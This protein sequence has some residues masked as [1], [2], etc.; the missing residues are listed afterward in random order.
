MPSAGRSPSNFTSCLAVATEATM[1]GC[2]WSLGIGASDHR[3]PQNIWC[4]SLV[5]GGPWDVP[6]RAVFSWLFAVLPSS[7]GKSHFQ[8]IEVSLSLGIVCS[9]RGIVPSG[10]VLQD[11]SSP[12][13][14]RLQHLQSIVFLC[15]FCGCF[16]K[17][18]IFP[19]WPTLADHDM[20]PA[21]PRHPI[22]PGGRGL[23]MLRLQ[24]VHQVEGESGILVL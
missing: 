6:K 12:R 11:A 5:Q 17:K 13:M 4:A 7:A 9:N 23:Q 8:V 3:N 21:E 19:S 20:G 16:W 1:A 22:V 18:F 10:R 2:F 14:I 24:L 15:V